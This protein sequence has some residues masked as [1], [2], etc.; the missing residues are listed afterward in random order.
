MKRLNYDFQ[1][2]Y[3]LH[4]FYE[5]FMNDKILMENFRHG[6]DETWG[7]RDAVLFGFM[8]PLASSRF[9]SYGKHF[10]DGCKT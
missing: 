8:D 3:R 10:L 5:I 2:F 6:R 7:G 9:S 1:F 4:N